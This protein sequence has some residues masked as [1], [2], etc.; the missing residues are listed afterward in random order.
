MSYSRN[1]YQIEHQ[2]G[3]KLP[4]SKAP[5]ARDRKTMRHWAL[6]GEIRS[7]AD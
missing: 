5:S 4:H 3:S 2:G 1:S 6:T 7:S